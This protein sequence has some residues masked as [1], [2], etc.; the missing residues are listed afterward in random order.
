MP[1]EN[2]KEKL[3]WSVLEYEEK[4]RHPDWFLAFGI[5]IAASSI[6]AIIY[7]NYFFAILI[8]L[9]GSLL[10]LYTIKQPKE[11][12]YELN[13]KGLKINNTLFPFENIKSFWIQTEVK[14]ILFLKLERPFMPIISVPLEFYLMNDVHEIFSKKNILEEKMEEHVS[15]KIMEYLGF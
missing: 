4:E 14:H 10:Y 6:T 15:E 8:I 11:I 1:L 2:L 13:N 3:N 5:I 7:G 9:S 12:F